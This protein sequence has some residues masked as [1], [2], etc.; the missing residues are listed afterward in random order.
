MTGFRYLRACCNNGL[1]IS[2]VLKIEVWTKLEK[3]DSQFTG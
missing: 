3:I 2:N 1:V